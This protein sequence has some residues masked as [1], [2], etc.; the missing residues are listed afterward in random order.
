MSESWKELGVIPEGRLQAFVYSELTNKI[1]INV[2]IED[3]GLFVNNLYIR[4][5]DERKYVKIYGE[6]NK[7]S[8]HDPLLMP[9]EKGLLT[10]IFKVIK[11]NGYCEFKWESLSLIHIKGFGRKEVLVG[12]KDSV[13]SVEGAWISQ[14]YSLSND[15]SKVYCS[16]AYPIEESDDKTTVEYWLCELCLNNVDINKITKLHGVFI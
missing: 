11:S 9:D 3:N 10:N 7:Y 8:F 16:I 12:T 6:S 5:I 4:N 14:L 13:L 1:I 2:A 15:G